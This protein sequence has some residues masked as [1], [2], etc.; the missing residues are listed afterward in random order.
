MDWG[1]LKDIASIVLWLLTVGGVIWKAST[2]ASKVKQNDEDIHDLKVA[3]D[4]DLAK[5]E[6]LQATVSDIKVTLGAISTKLDMILNYK[7]QGK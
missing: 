5:M 3:R 4:K 7:E 1:L 2:L 6:I